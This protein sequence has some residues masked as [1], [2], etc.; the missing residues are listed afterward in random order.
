LGGDATA[1]LRY[2]L[3]QA[4]SLNNTNRPSNIELHNL[5][6]EELLAFS[7]EYMTYEGIE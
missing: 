6:L 7:S 4:E 5:N 3:Q 2:V 1:Q